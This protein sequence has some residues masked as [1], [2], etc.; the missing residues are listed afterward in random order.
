MPRPLPR[1]FYR[2]DTI[3]VARDLLGCEIWVR[4]DG[5]SP[6]RGRIVE[7]EAYRGFDDRACHGWR[8][9]TPRRR[10][11]FGAG[12]QSFVYITYGI[13]HML[14]VVTE[15]PGYPSGVLIRAL[16]PVRNLS[17]STQGP[18]LLTEALGITRAQDGCDLR[19]GT[20]RV[21]A[22]A[23]RSEESIA[24]STRVGVEY[25]GRAAAAEPWRFFVAGNASVSPGRPTDPD[26]A[27]QLVTRRRESQRN[28][29]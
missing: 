13:H 27:E 11:L 20:V 4:H 1:R 26:R 25:A 14:N 2:R 17:G 19:R 23:L 10:S 3:D 8:G 7:V 16:E 18:G 12:G 29:G 28:R 9:E 5:E 24:T 21:L 6:R 22:G 15:D